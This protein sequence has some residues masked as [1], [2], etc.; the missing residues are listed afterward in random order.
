MSTYS[1]LRL[2][3]LKFCIE[4]NLSCSKSARTAIFITF[5]LGNFALPYLHFNSWLTVNYIFNK[6]NIFY[7]KLS[8]PQSINDY[9]Y[10]DPNQNSQVV[11]VFV[12]I[13]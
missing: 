10:F 12:H 1:L 9:R 3:I 6:I 2:I 11:L 13:Q 4:K 5:I 7:F 8:K